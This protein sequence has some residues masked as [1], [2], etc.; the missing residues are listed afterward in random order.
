MTAEFPTASSETKRPHVEG[1]YERMTD[2][3]S[4]RLT[5]EKPDKKYSILPTVMELAGD[6]KGKELVDCGTGDGFFARAAVAKG[7][8]EV[9]GIDSSAEQIALGQQTPL[10]NLEL[11]VG[12]IYKDEALPEADVILAPFMTD[13]AQN[14]GK[15][16]D[17][18]AKAFTAI[19]PGGR[20]V[21]V[22]NVPSNADLKRFGAEKRVEEDR[23]EA[24][25]HILLYDKHG[26]LLRDLT[27]VHY[28]KE[29][30]ERLL[31]EVGF[32]NVTWHKPIV[33]QEGIDEFGEAFWDGYIDNPELG[34]ITGEKR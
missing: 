30:V 10:K 22:V 17:F 4:Y 27:G 8:R 13:Y 7:A 33:A 5:H 3:E 18:F 34:Y 6:L 25:I 14:T 12:D 16:K 24:E 11:R 19:H 1:Q 32:T 28:T 29:T 15:L 21:L 2:V 20:I 9:V 23:D 31:N 26:N